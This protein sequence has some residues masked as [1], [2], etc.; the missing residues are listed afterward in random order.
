MSEKKSF[1][2]ES[3]PW[4]GYDQ[5][6]NDFGLHYE[7]SGLPVDGPVNEIQAEEAFLK[8]KEDFNKQNPGNSSKNSYIV[9]A[10]IIFLVVIFLALW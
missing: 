2:D 8:Y 10:A 7:Q 4:D 3:K 1:I 6:G 5:Q 9:A